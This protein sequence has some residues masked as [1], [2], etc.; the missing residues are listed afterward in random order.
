LLR[1]ALLDP[2][3]EML[4]GFLRIEVGHLFSSGGCA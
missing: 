3:T 2:V 4:E 1:D